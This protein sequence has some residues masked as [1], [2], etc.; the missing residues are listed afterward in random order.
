MNSYDVQKDYW[1]T[2]RKRR[3]PD[4][5]VIEAFALPKV[6]WFMDVIA[7][8]DG[9]DK[10]ATLLD[11]GCGNGFFSY[12]LDRYYK[13]TAL[14]FSQQMLKGNPLDSRVSASALELPFKDGSFDIVFCS[15][16][17]HHLTPPSKAVSEMARVA[18]SVVVLS[19]PN[20]NNPLMFLF[21]LLKSEERGTLSFTSGYLKS[22]I[23]DTGYKVAAAKSTG[24]I[25]PNK[26]PSFL[27]PIM[28]SLEWAI[29]PK[30]YTI[31]V[32]LK[33]K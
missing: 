1:E 31:A 9:P 23:K 7:N 29:F 4:D 8:F 18:K 5:P 2:S 13:V 6:S 24:G 20:R 28:K 16:L 19:E 15:N 32:G 26:T 30:F 10:G 21:G 3:G 14:D 22:L 25:L 27:L 17:L 11:V 33:K 12:Y